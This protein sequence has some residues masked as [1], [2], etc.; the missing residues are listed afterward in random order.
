MNHADSCI[1][2][3]IEYL[4]IRYAIFSGNFVQGIRMSLFNTK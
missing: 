1:T 2:T 3:F 4:W